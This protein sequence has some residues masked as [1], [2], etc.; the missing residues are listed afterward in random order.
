MFSITLH[1]VYITQLF[2]EYCFQYQGR[3]GRLQQWILPSAFISTQGKAAHF[4][5]TFKRRHLDLR[6]LE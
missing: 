5:F 2:I 3:R 6:R 1:D 4:H